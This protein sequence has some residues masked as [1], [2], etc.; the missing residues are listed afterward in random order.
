MPA[1]ARTRANSVFGTISDDP[2]EPGASSF[3]SN[4][5]VLLPVVSGGHAIIT[6]DPLRQFGDPEI[7]IVTAHTAASSVATI[8][9]GAYGTSAR[10]HP[11]LTV[12]AHALVNADTIEILTSSTRPA[13]PYIG[14]L[15]YETD[16]GVYKTW[17]GIA[18]DT[19]SGGPPPRM[20]WHLTRAANQAVAADGVPQSISYDTEVQDT[21]GNF[22]APSSTLTIPANGAGIWAITF[23]ADGQDGTVSL[24]YAK[25]MVIAG[26]MTFATTDQDDIGAFIIQQVVSV[27]VP[28]AAGNTILTQVQHS[29]STSQN[30][31]ARLTAYRL[32]Q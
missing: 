26:G 4:Q 12:W 30:Y 29:S 17:S 8:T 5:L 25:A 27:V 20:G 11:N 23:H 19:L 24:Q 15:I 16:N 1:G 22:T 7:V 10:S 9:R 31:K 6:L 28:L 2:L 21:P 14:E 18:W 13:D 3:N 32:T